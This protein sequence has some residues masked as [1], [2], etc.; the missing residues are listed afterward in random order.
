M[1]GVTLGHRG[2]QLKI[3]TRYRKRTDIWHLV[4]LGEN[5]LFKESPPSI[6]VTRNPNWSTEIL[7]WDWL[8]KKERCYHPLSVLP[9]AGCVA[10]SRSH[11]LITLA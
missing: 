6:M 7:W 5:V 8:R 2:D 9:K 3:I 4:L 10:M 11:K 1:R